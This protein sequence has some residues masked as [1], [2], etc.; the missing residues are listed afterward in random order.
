MSTPIN[1][2]NLVPKAETQASAFLQEYPN[3]DGKNVVVAVFD[4]GVDLGA[5]GVLLP[6]IFI[7]LIFSRSSTLS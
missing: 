1:W 7:S 2:N 3:Y 4:T 6:R 5:A